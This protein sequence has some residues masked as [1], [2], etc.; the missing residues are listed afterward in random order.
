MVINPFLIKKKIERKKEVRYH[1][2]IL[3][4]E[5]MFMRGYIYSAMNVITG[6][7]PRLSPCDRSERP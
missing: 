5:Q 1:I 6:D 7:L 4:V 3:V 2:D